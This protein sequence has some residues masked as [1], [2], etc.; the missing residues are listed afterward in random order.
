MSLYLQIEDT[1]DTRIVIDGDPGAGKTTFIK[2]LCY[3]WAKTVLQQDIKDEGADFLRKYTI[4]L[5]V[6]LRLVMKEPSL[7][8]IISSQ[9]GTLSIAEVCSVTLLI[10]SNP[11]QAIILQD[12]FDEYE[13]T[14]IVS[15][16]IKKEK[17][18]KVLCV[19]TSRPHSVEVLRRDT[20]QAVDQLVK[21]C[22]FS[23]KQV[24]EYIMQYCECHSLHH[25]KGD[26]L[27]E[28]LQGK[29]DLLKIAKTPIR[30]EMICIV[31]EA[32]GRLGN[33]LADLYEMFVEHLIQHW[34]Y[35]DKPNQA[36][37]EQDASF[38]KDKFLINIG[39]V[40]NQ[41]ENSRLRIV[42]TTKELQDI[43][44]NDFDHAIKIGL[45]LKSHPCNRLDVSKW[46]FP[47]LTI[48]E[49][50]LACLLG[51]GTLVED[52]ILKCKDFRVL[53]RTE[54]IFMFMC[55]KYPDTANKILSR[56]LLEEKDEQKCD[57]LFSFICKIIPH[58]TPSDVNIP[59][60]HCLSLPR[61]NE[62]LKVIELLMKKSRQNMTVLEV[63]S[64]F[65]E[66]ERFLSVPCV[67]EFKVN[68][69]NNNDKKV[70]CS[71]LKH[72]TQLT[73]FSIE[74]YKKRKK[75]VSLTV[76]DNMDIFGTI[77]SEKLTR[78]RVKGECALEAVTANIHRF[79]SLQQ[80]FVDERL[81]ECN[82]THGK[83]ILSAL[84]ENCHAEEFT[85]CV[86]DMDIDGMELPENHKMKV[87]FKIRSIS[88]DTINKMVKFA[89]LYK[90]DLSYNNLKDKGE[91]LGQMLV[92]MKG[93][94]VLF[95]CSTGVIAETFQTTLEAMQSHGGA[96]CSLL[97]LNLDHR[98]SKDVQVEGASYRFL[99]G[100]L[101]HMPELHTLDLWRYRLKPT[102]LESIAEVL[103]PMTK[104]RTLTLR[105]NT[106]G[107]SD[108]GGSQLLLR[109]PELDAV[110]VGAPQ[111]E[112]PVPSL[113]GAA[114]Y[115]NQL[116]FLDMFDSVT[117]PGSL[118][119]LG[120]HLSLMHNLEVINLGW[121]TGAMPEDYKYVYG[122]LGKSVK[123][124]DVRNRE[125]ALCPYLIL[126]SQQSLNNLHRLNVKL[127]DSDIKLIQEV[128]EEH[129]P[130]VTVYY[131]ES[132]DT[133]GMYKTN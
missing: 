60:P 8:D 54:V 99:A 89:G 49:Y 74:S 92:M 13:G 1:G 73:S 130:D 133:W 37:A 127:T 16:I 53:R 44:G 63:R 87:S 121:I 114:E 34:S 48:Q 85:L 122:N 65:A 97:E 100:V 26:E 69:S 50:L 80:L 7:F 104:M 4:L 3:V 52:F 66:F 18:P 56:L 110:R 120:E 36:R 21:L 131:D 113:C 70:L 95:I 41:W 46:S 27:F 30:T 125:I 38:D 25:H 119:K 14:S 108:G 126:Q 31:W 9:L 17:N 91:L 43:L 51:S 62:D 47:H 40:C 106:L 129:N 79:K 68:I 101:N 86:P 28:T 112:D 103:K 39:K 96:S 6:I 64:R 72:F 123:H 115:L 84:Q 23:E 35:K 33:T 124:L 77:P 32:Y 19:T 128:L 11:N 67:K 78:L 2:R 5:P 45:V 118:Q 102:D 29:P 24:K 22:G 76:S 42:F 75:R 61:E 90:L 116:R 82:K 15:K 109:M 58:F 132:E 105:G 20:S 12:G 117:S 81:P 55:Y 88:Q 10:D 71:K 83:K 57:K 93:L 94:R 107:D 98:R 111:Y 59:L